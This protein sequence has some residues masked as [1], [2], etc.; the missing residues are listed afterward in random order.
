[1][2]RTFVGLVTSI[3]RPDLNSFEWQR[4]LRPDFQF[5]EIIIIIVVVVV[6]VMKL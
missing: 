1:M 4:R 6:V 2:T 5:L 3:S